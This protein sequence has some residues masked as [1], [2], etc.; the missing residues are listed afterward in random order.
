MNKA[1]K[2]LLAAIGLVLILAAGAAAYR[3]QIERQ[4]QAEEATVLLQEGI[5]QFSEERF[6]AALET[7]RNIPEGSLVDWR[8]PY[9][10]GATLIKLAD[11]EAAALLLEEAL[12]LNGNEKDIPFALGVVYYKLGNLGLSKSYFH[13][14]LEIDPNDQEAKGLMDIMAKLERHQPKE[15]AAESESE[16]SETALPEN[17]PQISDY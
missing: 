14:V 3:Y 10:M 16:S 11:Y 1:R 17:H 6:E 5:T 4:R 7:L 15:A 12:A 2:L 9:Y 13:S 8:I